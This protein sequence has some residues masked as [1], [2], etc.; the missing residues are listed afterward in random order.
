M[1]AELVRA[2]DPPHEMAGMAFEKK[3]IF[4]LLNT[5][6][7][8]GLLFDDNDEQGSYLKCENY[9][10]QSESWGKLTNM[11]RYDVYVQA[12][13]P[14][15]GKTHSEFHRL[16]FRDVKNRGGLYTHIKLADTPFDK[17]KERY[18]IVRAAEEDALLLTIVTGSATDDFGGAPIHVT[19]KVGERTFALVVEE[20]GD[21]ASYS[22]AYF[23]DVTEDRT[24]NRYMNFYF[25]DRVALQDGNTD[26]MYDEIDDKDSYI[27]YNLGS[28]KPLAPK[29]VEN[30]EAA[31]S[32]DRVRWGVTK[33]KKP[34]LKLKSCWNPTRTLSAETET[35]LQTT[36]KKKQRGQNLFQSYKKADPNKLVDVGAVL[37]EDASFRFLWTNHTTVAMQTQ[38]TENIV[39]WEE[40]DEAH[41]TAAPEEPRHQWQLLRVY[42]DSGARCN[43]APAA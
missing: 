15:G 3:G 5:E 26:L 29:A 30:S 2:T 8:H 40:D 25:G 12:A 14:K 17:K 43:A 42:H 16:K 41:G 20:V 19:T 32:H 38:S 6:S 7:A 39:M 1:N 9:G 34:W 28:K 31:T 24:A 10:R 21:K 11:Y 13:K 37:G 36:G 23:Q 35:D 33:G 4:K 22:N 18:R 27:I